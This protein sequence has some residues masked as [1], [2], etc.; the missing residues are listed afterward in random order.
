MTSDQ[1]KSVLGK[2]T[3]DDG[4]TNAI[5]IHRN[6]AGKFIGN[7]FINVKKMIYMENENA[8]MSLLT[9]GLQ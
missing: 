3:A 2:T 1:L 8:D 4:N 7:Y 6:Q 9:S 5:F